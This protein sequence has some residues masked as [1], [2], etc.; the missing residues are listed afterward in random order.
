MLLNDEVQIGVGSQGSVIVKLRDEVKPSVF[1]RELT[2]TGRSGLWIG[3]ID[4]ANGGVDLAAPPGRYL[5]TGW[6]HQEDAPDN[7]FMLLG[8]RPI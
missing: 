8:V 1:E 7:L 4:A 6:F 2:V 5:L 3:S